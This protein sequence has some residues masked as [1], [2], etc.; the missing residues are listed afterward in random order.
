MAKCEVRRMI[1]QEKC[2][3]CGKELKGQ[4]EKNQCLCSDCYWL[5]RD[6]KRRRERHES[7]T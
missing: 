7:Q 4:K 3:I 6:V 1:E 5:R 2:V